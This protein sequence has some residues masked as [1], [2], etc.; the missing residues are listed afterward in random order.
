MKIEYLETSRYGAS[1]MKYYY[2]THPELNGAQAYLNLEGALD[3]LLEHPLGGHPY[4][5]R[6]DV[7]EKS[8]L[9]TP[10]SLLYVA[11]RDTIFVVDIRDSRGMRSARALREF[12]RKVRGKYNI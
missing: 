3:Y 12:N 10:F 2:D 8:I 11:K 7:R 6:K 9:Q 5:G 1:W 4:N